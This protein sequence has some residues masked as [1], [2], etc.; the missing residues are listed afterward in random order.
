MENDC[1]QLVEEY[2]LN[3]KLQAVANLQQEITSEITELSQ[4]TNYGLPVH[5]P[6]VMRSQGNKSRMR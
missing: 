4:Q 5:M 2:R 1:Q 3:G 6:K